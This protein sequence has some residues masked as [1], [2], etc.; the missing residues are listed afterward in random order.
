MRLR[1]VGVGAGVATCGVG[2][3]YLIN[4]ASNAAHLAL[5]ALLLGVAV[6]LTL[7]QGTDV[8]IG[9]S[10]RSVSRV[11][12]SFVLRAKSSADL[13]F[14]L[15]FSILI[16]ISFYLAWAQDFFGWSPQ[17]LDKFHE[18]TDANP[19][20]VQKLIWGAFIG[21]FWLHLEAFRSNYLEITDR[22]LTRKWREGDISYSSG[23]WRKLSLRIPWSEVDEVRLEDHGLSL[24]L[25]ASASLANW[26]NRPQSVRFYLPA[27]DRYILIFTA[28]EIR[29]RW[30]ELDR[31]LLRF[32]G[33][34]YRQGL[35]GGD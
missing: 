17:L 12:E 7:A 13:Y 8:E 16:G 2:A 15:C 29:G 14:Y 6:L 11:S 4:L 19:S 35:I 34:K 27:D 33:S 26:R 22:Y 20:L 28:K 32:A 3:A 30:I 21:M 24:W 18:A 5:V 9:S 31:T 23:S 25:S 10:D 1:R